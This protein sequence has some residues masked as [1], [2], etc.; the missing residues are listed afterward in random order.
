MNVVI[1][2]LLAAAA[3]HLGLGSCADK[4]AAV[5]AMQTAYV[6]RQQGGSLI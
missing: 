2:A 3:A 6:Q 1:V 5:Q 4:G